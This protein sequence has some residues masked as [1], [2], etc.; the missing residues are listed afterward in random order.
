MIAETANFPYQ[1]SVVEAGSRDYT[2]GT[3][4]QL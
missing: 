4:A 1:I 3:P 2:P